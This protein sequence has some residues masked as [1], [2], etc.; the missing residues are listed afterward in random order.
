MES[1]M[2]VLNDLAWVLV[3]DEEQQVAEE[4]VTETETNG[5]QI[6]ETPPK[7]VKT[8][9]QEEVNKIMAED[10][11]KQQKNRDQLVSQL[12]TISENKNLTEKERDE[13]A[14]RIEQLQNE[15]MTAQEVAKR[16]KEKI[17]KDYT[18]QVDRERADKERI[19]N[20]YSNEKITREIQDAA[21]EHDAVSTTQIVNLLQPSCKVIDELG[22]EGQ[23]TGDY[24][25]RVAFRDKD[26]KGTTITLELNVTDAVKR[27]KEMPEHWNLFKSG[28]N[29]GI[30]LFNTPQSVAR[31]SKPPKNPAEYR[32]WREN[33]FGGKK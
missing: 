16:E 11:R 25:T 19:W 17:T 21:I 24:V 2:N 18:K 28:A 15:T 33:V 31:G 10:R 3:Y 13:L 5:E 29:G 12:K 20:K 23:P 30:G 6:P 32:K 1:L 4:E 8:F 27:M 9:T 14:T 22:K 26:D 7:N